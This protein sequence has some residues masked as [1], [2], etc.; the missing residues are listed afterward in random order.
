MAHNLQNDGGVSLLLEAG[1]IA[2]GQP[3]T[4]EQ[5]EKTRS[6]LESRL[7]DI[8]VFDPVVKIE[9]DNLIRVEAPG[10]GSLDDLRAVMA[11]H[12]RLELVEGGADPPAVGSYIVTDLEGP[13]L[14]RPDAQGNSVKVW[15]TVLTDEDVDPAG[16]RFTQ[17]PTR[18]PDIHV[19]F[20]KDG[21]R[22][23]ADFTTAN[24]MKYMPI[25][26]DKQVVSVPLIID[27][28]RGGEAAI[29]TQTSNQAIRLFVQLKYGP[30]PVTLKE[31]EAKVIPIPLPHGR[32]L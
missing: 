31:L 6:T 21:A 12:V 13:P 26:L 10:T 15:P 23:L 5:M 20:T 16:V 19:T 22:K 9:G 29:T 28:M 32:D 18:S 7:W 1:P 30:L 25:A 24:T 2:A 27:P 3:V 4:A 8:G 14:D 17:S 11:A